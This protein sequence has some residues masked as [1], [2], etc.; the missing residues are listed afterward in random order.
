MT[1]IQMSHISYRGDAPGLT[2]VMGGRI[3]V[4]FPGLASAVE[5]AHS[6][7]LRA[8][9]VTTTTRSK[10][11]PEV[12]TV[13]EFVPG[14]ESSTWYGFV[15]PKGTPD[16]VVNTINREVNAGLVDPNLLARIA[17]LGGEAIPMTPAG[18]K[19]F[20]AEET[21]KYAEVV[22]VTNMKVP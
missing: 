7:K 17:A 2:D 14:F 13:A 1:G 11:L 15:A 12:P 6:G 18:F 16:E 21:K 10:V 8:L 22:R 3:Q 4:Y 5:L 20:I 9:G 19:A